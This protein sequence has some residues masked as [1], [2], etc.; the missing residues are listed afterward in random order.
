MYPVCSF[1]ESFINIHTLLQGW[2]RPCVRFT[3]S[4]KPSSDY[5]AGS[6]SGLPFSTVGCGY[7]GLS[8][9]KCSERNWG[10][11]GSTRY[12][13]ISFSSSSVVTFLIREMKVKLCSF[14]ELIFLLLNISFFYFSVYHS[15]AIEDKAGGA[16]HH[17]H[18][19][20]FSSTLSELSNRKKVL[21]THWVLVIYSF[22]CC[23]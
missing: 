15:Q 21:G 13:L 14:S 1:V 6:A 18:V 20:Y 23:K 8:A 12:F 19:N 9:R 2:V 10:R 4:G 7:C 3:P 5:S 17:A 22:C 11:S 16:H